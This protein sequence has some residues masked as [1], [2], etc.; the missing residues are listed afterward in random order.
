[1]GK[2]P[3]E[4]G[5]IKV[6]NAKIGDYTLIARRNGSDW[7]IG[8][9]TDWEKRSFEIS[10]DFLADGLYEMKYIE[11]G[12]NADTRAIDYKL[13]SN[14]I[15]KNDKMTIHLV[16]GGGWIARINKVK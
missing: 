16:P 8:T 1:L 10:F 7:Y 2:I 13:K 6:L 11:D 5:D 14:K 15:T 12:I 9:I 3:E 4:W